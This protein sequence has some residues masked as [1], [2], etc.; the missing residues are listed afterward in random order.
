MMLPYLPN[1]RRQF[2]PQDCLPFTKRVSR[3]GLHLENSEW[4]NVDDSWG[5]LGAESIG[6]GESVGAQPSTILLVML[7]QGHNN[8]Q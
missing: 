3:H 8:I 2:F 4:L 1:D 6:S 7:A 5:V